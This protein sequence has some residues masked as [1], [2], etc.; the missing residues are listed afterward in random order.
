MQQQEKPNDKGSNPRLSY[1]GEDVAGSAAADAH[2]LQ[3]VRRPELKVPSESKQRSSAIGHRATGPRTAAG[4]QRSSR[5][6]VKY[7]IFAKA[8]LLRGEPRAG[9]ESLLAGLQKD[10]QPQGTLETALVENLAAVLWRKQRLV[11]AESAEITNAA[12][13]KSVDSIQAQ[14]REVW[15]RS[16]AG[17]IKG[18]MARPSSNPYLI[19]ESID[20]L[21]TVRNGLEKVGFRKGEDPYLLRK[22]YGLDHDDAAPFGV[23]R[24]YQLFSKLASGDLKGHDPSYSPDELKKQMI[25][26]FDGE[27][28]RLEFTELVQQHLAEERGAYH[29][30]AALIPSQDALDRFVR[31][32]AHLSR[33]LDRILNR[34]ERLQ[35]MRLGQPASPTLNVKINE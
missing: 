4:K 28:Q 17:E 14:L 3:N 24:M 27:I 12:G 10:L 26:V 22:L 30:I 20:I 11:H 25:Q 15:D 7:G 18:G 9:Y 31:Y 13:F 33:E 2:Q 6:S 34:L 35:R 21:T 16:R 1:S 8:V 5:N 19:R 29:A 23:F 32:E